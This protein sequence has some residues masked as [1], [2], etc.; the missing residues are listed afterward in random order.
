MDFLKAM[1]SDHV[2]RAGDWVAVDV[3]VAVVQFG[4]VQRLVGPESIRSSVDTVLCPGFAIRLD[5][6]ELNAATARFGAQISHRLQ[7]ERA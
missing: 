6:F 3:A 7:R 4:W 2:P 5:P 1:G